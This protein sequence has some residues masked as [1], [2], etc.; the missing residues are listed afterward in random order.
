MRVADDWPRRIQPGYTSGIISQSRI[1]F[2]RPASGWTASSRWISRCIAA[3]VSTVISPESGAESRERSSVSRPSVSPSAIY[4]VIFF[5]P[6]LP[7]LFFFPPFLFPRSATAYDADTAST[8]ARE[9]GRKKK[10][11]KRTV[12]GSF[13]F[14]QRVRACGM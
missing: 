2:D 8:R 3:C 6:L 4:S 14:L 13:E 5:T 7:L 9:R 10:E 12:T 1:L 11:K